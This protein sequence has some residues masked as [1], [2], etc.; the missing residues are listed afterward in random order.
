MA[1]ATFIRQN[2]EVILADWEQFARTMLPAA[3]GLDPTALRDGAAE[4]IRTIADHAEA[5]RPAA[6]RRHA[7][8]RMTATADRHAAERLTQQFT[9]KQLVAEYLALRKSVAQRWMEQLTTTGPE[10]MAELARFNEAVDQALSETIEAYDARLLKTEEGTRQSEKRYQ[11]LAELS[12]DAI[13][14]HVRDRWVYANPAAAR[15]IGLPTPEALI[16]RPVVEFLHVSQHA[17]A[18]D[19]AALVLAGGSVSPIEYQL[20]KPYGHTIHVEVVAAPI[21]W[22]GEDAA[23]IIVRDVTDRKNAQ[24]SLRDAHRTQAS[25]RQFLETLL[26]NAT[27]CIAV[28]VGPDLR[29]TLVNKAY[30]QLR[31][32]VPM[33]GRCFREVFPEAVASGADAGIHRVMA[34]A[35]RHEDTGFPMPIAGKPNAAWDHLIAPLPVEPGAPP[36]VLVM[37]REVT[38]RVRMQ[39]ALQSSEARYRAL[40]AASSDVLYRMNADWSEMRELDGGGF[41]ADTTRPT[42]TWIEEYL[43]PDDRRRVMKAIQ[44]AVQTKSVFEL[45]HRVRRADGSVGWTQSRAVPLLDEHDTLT[46][47]FGA[48]SDITERRRAE[49]ALRK[50]DRAKDEFLAVLGHEL[51]NPLAPLR[52]GLELLGQ[53]RI[54]PELLDSLRPMMERQLTHLTRLVDDLLDIAR[55]SRG[56]IQLQRAPLDLHLA[57]EAALEQVSAS[58][59]ARG[60]Q[61]K[62][63]LAPAPLPVHGDFER[64]TQIIT[65]LLSNAAKYSPPGGAISVSSEVDGDHAV[66]RVRDTGYGIPADRMEDL[67]SLFTQIPDHREQTGGGGLGI[68]LAL[69]QQLMELHGGAIEAHSDGPGHGSEFTVR[70]PITRSPR[71]AG[72]A[73]DETQS[74]A[75]PQQRVLVVDDN[76]DAADTLGMLLEVHGHRVRIAH[77]GPSA[78]QQ[79]ADFDPHVVLLD[80][81]LPGMHGLEVARRIRAMPTGSQL[82]LIAVTG[83]GQDEDRQRT[84]EAGFDHHLTKPIN[85]DQ[86]SALIV[87]R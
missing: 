14:V 86:V 43:H 72:A 22:Q 13:L 57:I 48:A 54:R 3:D 36:A 7:A 4:I 15:L 51:R 58:I 21:R 66:V 26:D 30:Q 85:L 78:L 16:G 71:S 87:G 41:L 81:G 12:P 69:S 77:D 37:T 49:E 83:W 6:E 73:N 79:A 25:Q 8:E 82:L 33:I 23:Q 61:L 63:N 24:A 75:A 50:A 55:I 46:G 40:A 74:V 32:D 38:E 10:E 76:V 19:R 31:P 5:R 20:M 84:A 64:L 11:T 47:W 17:T 52:T 42:K 35:Q 67:F 80:L 68:G 27:I 62:V 34:T 70:L 60:H 2:F 53:A 39:A 9:L 65:N 56:K 18:R 44:R 45:E 59:D 28:M 1:V 29:Y